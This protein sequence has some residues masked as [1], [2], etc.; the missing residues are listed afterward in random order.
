MTREEALLY[1]RIGG[2]VKHPELPGK[3]LSIQEGRVR[4]LKDGLP[5]EYS[6]RTEE[7]FKDGWEVVERH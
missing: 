7:I 2:V 4:F 1:M 3:S 5:Y 6:F